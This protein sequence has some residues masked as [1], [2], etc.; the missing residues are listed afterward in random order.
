MPH[1]ALFSAPLNRWLLPSRGPSRAPDYPRGTEGGSLSS[2]GHQAIISHARS[3]GSV[4]CWQLTINCGQGPEGWGLGQRGLETWVCAK[5]PHPRRGIENLSPF[6][7]VP[8]RGA[9]KESN[10]KEPYPSQA[11]GPYVTVSLLHG[12]ALLMIKGLGQVAQGLYSRPRS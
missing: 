5:T 4:R 8:T 6:H 2:F 11:L 9:D 1:L 7:C 3:R 12:S 10:G